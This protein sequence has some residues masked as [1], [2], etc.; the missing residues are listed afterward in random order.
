MRKQ[1]VFE[2]NTKEVPQ[3][4]KVNYPEK[5]FRAGAISATVWHNRGHLASGEESEFR[6]VSLERSYTDKEGKWQATTTLRV[7]DLPRA[8]AALHKA[9]EYL[10]FQEP[11]MKGGN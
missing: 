11:D 7:N 4:Q 1:E 5:K 9:Y 3:A 8:E 10:V 2:M 6:T